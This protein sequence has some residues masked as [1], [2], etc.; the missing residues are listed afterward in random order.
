M[1]T[2]FPEDREQVVGTPL[3]QALLLLSP[4]SGQQLTPASPLI[5]STC[6]SAAPVGSHPLWQSFPPLSD[7]FWSVT[8]C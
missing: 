1:H 2:S 4:S 5:Q 6:C 7:P 8:P 3:P